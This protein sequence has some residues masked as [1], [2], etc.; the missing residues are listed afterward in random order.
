M[1]NTERTTPANPQSFVNALLDHR[2][3]RETVSVSNS[4]QTT[5]KTTTYPSGAQTSKGK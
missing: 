2:L 3:I 5:T 4:A 1:T